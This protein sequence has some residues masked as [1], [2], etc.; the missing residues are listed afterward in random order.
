MIQELP[1]AVSGITSV[2]QLEGVTPRISMRG[3]K[4]RFGSIEALCGVNQ[5]GRAHV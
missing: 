1:S 2:L 4:K 3:I 5:I